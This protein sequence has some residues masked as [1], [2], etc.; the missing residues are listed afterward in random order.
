M[1]VI[2]GLLAVYSSSYALGYAEYGDSAYFVKRQVLLGGMGLVGMLFASWIDYRILKRLSPLLMLVA[3]AGLAA[4]LLPGVATDLNGASRWVS[5]GGF[6]VQPSEF[7]KL[8]VIVYLAAW[9]AAK[10]NTVQDVALGVIPFTGMV[11]LVAALVLLEPDLGTATLIALVTGTLFFISGA[12]LFHLVAVAATAA[13]F[14]ATLILVGG[15][16]MGRITSFTSAEADPEGLG[17]QTLQ[18]LVALGSGGV[19]GLG[20]GVSR[21]KFFYLPASHTDG[22]IAIV[23]EELGY[24]GVCVVLTLFVLLLWRG[25]RIV[26]RAADPFGSLLAAGV[27]AW[28]GFQVLMNVGGVTRT[29]PLTG[30]PLPFL[31]YGGSSLAMLMIAI[32]VLLSVSRYAATEDPAREPQTRGVVRTSNARTSPARG[33]S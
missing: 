9:L 12:R 20:L 22:V 28:I 10:G 24:I 11:G 3:L 5:I 23:G 16:G 26:R 29:I 1:L 7:A 32:G 6:T 33:A 31:S 17:F 15:Y 8:A 14:T 19:T 2:L 27:L 21:Q 30:I 18:M 25:M 4:V 13:L